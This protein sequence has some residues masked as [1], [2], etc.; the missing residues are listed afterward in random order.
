MANEFPGIPHDMREVY[1]RFE[2][3]RRARTGRL[4]NPER[5]WAAAVQ[6]GREHGFF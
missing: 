2:R 3:L 4:P 1:Q 6:L 5:L